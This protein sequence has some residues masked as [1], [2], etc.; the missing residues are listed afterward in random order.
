MKGIEKARRG[1]PT[2]K[3][4]MNIIPEPPSQEYV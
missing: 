1:A 3:R 2:P 4:A